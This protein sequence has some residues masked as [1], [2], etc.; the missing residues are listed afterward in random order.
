MFDNSLFH[1]HI[2]AEDIVRAGLGLEEIRTECR[3]LKFPDRIYA[4]NLRKYCATIA[5]VSIWTF[6]LVAHCNLFWDVTVS[7]S[8]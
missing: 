5:Q 6:Y 1:R 8:K 4:T 3:S 2:S 7:K